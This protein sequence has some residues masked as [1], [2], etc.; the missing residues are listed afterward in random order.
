MLNYWR[1]T[2]KDKLCSSALKANIVGE[3]EVAKTVFVE[4]GEQKCFRH[5][6]EIVLLAE[7]ITF[8]EN[9]GSELFCSNN[10]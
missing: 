8:L 10:G 4:I 7:K 3:N 9:L 6:P 5:S 1:K 2:N